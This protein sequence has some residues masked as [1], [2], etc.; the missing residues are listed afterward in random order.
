MEEDPGESRHL[1]GEMPQ[2]FQQ[3]LSAYE[4]YTKKNKVPPIPAGYDHRKQLMLNALHALLR[5]PLIIALLWLLV[6]LPFYIGYRVKT[7]SD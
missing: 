4:H 6:L 7:G 1:A 2:Q 5:E 3:M